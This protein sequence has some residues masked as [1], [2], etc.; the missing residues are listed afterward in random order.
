MHNDRD[1]RPDD[2][3]CYEIRDALRIKITGLTAGQPYTV[4]WYGTWDVNGPHSGFYATRTGRALP[5]EGVLWVPVGDL[6]CTNRSPD[7]AWDGADALLV[8]EPTP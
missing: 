8:I 4:R 1:R 5:N 7:E 2:T 6:S 3:S